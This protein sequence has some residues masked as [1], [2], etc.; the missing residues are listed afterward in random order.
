MK[1]LLATPL[2]PPEIGGAA[3][4]VKELAQ[5]LRGRHEVT[6][7]AYA[8]LPEKVPG[9]RIVAID[10]RPPLPARLFRYTAALLRAAGDADILYAQNGASVELPAGIAALARRAPLIMHIGDEAAH[11][12]AAG[13]PLLRRI[14]RF[15]FKRAAK[16]VTDMPLA[17]P[18]ILPLEKAPEQELAAY[19][20]SWGNHI[21]ALEGIFQHAKK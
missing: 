6:I 11:R 10:K 4:Y 20:A 3:P 13:N 5:R 1:V 2:Y 16:I 19:E 7:V 8:H 18:E 17:R 15:A 14:E 9:V 12:R 21:N